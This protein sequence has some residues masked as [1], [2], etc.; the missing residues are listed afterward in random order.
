MSP[1][2]ETGRGRRWPTDVLLLLVLL[3]L[4]VKVTYHISRARDL[5]MTDDVSYMIWAAAIPEHG[6]PPA[7]YCPLYALW[8]HLLSLLQPNRVRLFYLSWQI[9]AFL[10][11][12]SVY[13]LGRAMGSGRVIALVVAFLVLTSAV[14]EVWP[15]SNLLAFVVVA[16]GTAL[17]ARSRSSSP[18]LA[19]ALLG[20]TLLTS[21]YV[22]PELAVAFLVFCL[23]ALV[24]TAWAV[25]RRQPEARRLTL[26]ALVV[27]GCAAVA[28][29]GV[30][31][32][33]GGGR[34]FIAF[35]QHYA[36]NVVAAENLPLNP[37]S[38]YPTIV[39]RDFGK[40][41]TL[42]EALEANP[43]ALLW[44]AWYN[45][46]HT[47]AALAELTEMKLDLA[48]DA[49]RL[50]AGVL[51]GAIVVGVGG[52]GL[53]LL[54]RSEG[55][56]GPTVVLLVLAVVMVPT[57]AAVLLISPESRYLMAVVLLL[58]TLGG[59]GLGGFGR[60]RAVWAWLDRPLP[61]LG[62]IVVFLAVAPNRAH[63]WNVQAL[64]SRE[65]RPAPPLLLHQ[66]IVEVMQRLSLRRPSGLLA[67]DHTES[68]YTFYARLPTRS[69]PMTAKSGPFWNFIRQVDVGVI[70]L[71]PV[72]VNWPTYRGDP[73]FQE[74]EAGKRRGDF[75]FFA[76]PELP[77]RIAVRKDLLADSAVTIAAR[78]D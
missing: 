28:F 24:R 76:V 77:V 25:L 74:F 58:T 59:A 70:V 45:V 50:L 53:R 38:E 69:V 68:D 11:P 52:L 8:Y 56:E 40:A 19:Q 75:V 61:L 26:A 43:R 20:L 9:L 10:V 5:D 18:A 7:D 46:R 41:A 4:S 39:A 35:G 55:R 6:L 33:L 30:G 65:P 12:A 17:A 51:L 21:A 57:A 64:L 47:P 3:A 27:L 29:R 36:A 16:L 73:E 31:N 62:L 49:G 22:R 34:S 15:Y 42:R 14:V 54:R 13:V 71:E 66:R 67:L 63:G 1:A 78:H 48:Q 32:P 44:H 23:A 60:F 72:L 37:W 2:C